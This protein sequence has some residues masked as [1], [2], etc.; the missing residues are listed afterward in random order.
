MKRK[1][2]EDFQINGTPMLNPDRGIG[3]EENDI[4]SE[5]SGRDESGFMHYFVVRKGVKTWKFVYSV[6]E[7]DEYVYIKNQLKDKNGFTFMYKDETGEIH[8]TTAY[9]TKV[10]TEY[11]S[12]RRGVYK[13]LEF[14]INES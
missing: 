3:Y 4:M 2:I 5:D 7:P 13:N 11:W 12:A 9:S 6:L 10:S 14:E 1:F 8:Q